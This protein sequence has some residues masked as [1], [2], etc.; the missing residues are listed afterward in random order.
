MKRSKNLRGAMALLAPLF[1][2]AMYIYIAKTKPT[3]IGRTLDRIHH[4][5]VHINTVLEKLSIL[6]LLVSQ[7][8]RK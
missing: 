3:I 8:E 4:Y 7:L 2:P 1:P 6:I 5:Y